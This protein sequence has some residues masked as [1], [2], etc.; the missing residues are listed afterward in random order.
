M[1]S[2]YRLVAVPDVF[3]PGGGVRRGSL[4]MTAKQRM[5]EA[6]RMIWDE[7]GLVSRGAVAEGRPMTGP[8]K[9]EYAM[10][11]ARAWELSLLILAMP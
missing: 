6:R 8:E 7:A 10:L 5:E 3:L 11:T 1:G 4:M 2:D 9:A